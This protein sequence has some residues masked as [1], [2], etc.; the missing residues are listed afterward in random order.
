VIIIRGFA[1]GKKV[2]EEEHDEETLNEETAKRQLMRLTK[3][4]TK[5][6]LEIEFPD[7]PM[8]QRFLRI[9]SDKRGMVDPI[10]IHPREQIQ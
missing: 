4:S 3:I 7:L 8:D 5:I 6:M 10:Q 2:F 9:G 1:N